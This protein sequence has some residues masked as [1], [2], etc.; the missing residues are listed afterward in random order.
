MLISKIGKVCFR[1]AHYFYKCTQK[2]MLCTICIARQNYTGHL[3]RPFYV[4]DEKR[5]ENEVNALIGESD[6][7]NGLIHFS[8]NMTITFRDKNLHIYTMM[9]FDS[10][11]V[12]RRPRLHELDRDLN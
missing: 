6:F 9:N 5:T 10:G 12:P 2:T 11:K 4:K 3:I 7:M 1:C 8:E